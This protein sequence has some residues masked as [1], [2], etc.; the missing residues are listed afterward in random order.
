MGGCDNLIFKFTAAESSRC[1][2]DPVFSQ[3]ALLSCLCCKKNLFSFN[4]WLKEVKY[5][6]QASF[7]CN[8]QSESNSISHCSCW[9]MFNRYLEQKSVYSEQTEVDEKKKLDLV[10]CGN[11]VTNISKYWIN[12]AKLLRFPCRLPAAPDFLSLVIRAESCCQAALTVCLDEM[13]SNCYRTEKTHW[14]WFPHTLFQ[15]VNILYWSTPV[16]SDCW[17]EFI[18]ILTLHLEIL[19]I[20]CVLIVNEHQQSVFSPYSPYSNRINDSLV[21]ST[22]NLLFLLEFQLWFCSIYLSEIN[23]RAVIHK[24]V[25]YKVADSHHSSVWLLG[26]F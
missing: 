13:L 22:Q 14:T 4:Q 11:N 5:Q 18:Y 21:D 24:S 10:N 26:C 23:V 12:G 25:L 15:Y 9:Q 3:T 7:C 17:F 8:F 6:H 20:F 1:S 16:V 19:C 2:L